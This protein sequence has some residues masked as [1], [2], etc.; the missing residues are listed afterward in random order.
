MAASGPQHT[1]RSIGGGR[2]TRRLYGLVAVLPVAVWACG[3]GAGEAGPAAAG[4]DRV[5]VLAS[6]YPLSEAAARVGG[7]VASV[8]NLTPSGSEP[9]DL[10]LTPPQVEALEAADVVLTVG[11]GFQPG[12]EEV[13]EGRSGETVEVLSALDLE[14][15]RASTDDR[16]DQGGGL[17]PHVWLDPTK[18]GEIVDAV[19]V[20]LT[21]A[22]PDD[23][24]AFEAN[25]SAYKVQLGAL[26]ASY[27][28]ALASCE[29]DVMVV[30]HDAFGWLARRY[31]LTQE[32]IAGISPE[33][34]P[35]PQ[36][37]AELVAYVEDEGV[38]TVFTESLVSPAVAET[39]AREA[40]V[41]TE[42]LNPLEGLTDEQLAAGESYLTIME[43]NL[44][45]LVGALGCE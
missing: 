41:T 26:D 3:G 36:R 24:E 15:G 10:E 38:T 31:G 2:A 45:V 43:A 44:A 40:R 22:R 33:Q 1:D 7:D 34:E 6:F 4:G 37:L 11:R 17:D 9:H 14:P 39:L 32:A 25:A 8:E 16:D 20:A 28:A 12:V 21:E 29:R 35:D 30:A 23:A 27:E 13:A 5:T 42:V 18:M 19:A